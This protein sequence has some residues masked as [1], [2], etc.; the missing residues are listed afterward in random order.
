MNELKSIII[1]ILSREIYRDEEIQI[2]DISTTRGVVGFYV[3]Y[4]KILHYNGSVI[5][6]DTT[7]VPINFIMRYYKSK[8]I[9]NN[10]IDK[11]ESID[12]YSKITSI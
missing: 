10:R 2:L 4:Q 5:L 9:S 3:T 6:S 12:F 7:Y 11:L 8:K 1:K